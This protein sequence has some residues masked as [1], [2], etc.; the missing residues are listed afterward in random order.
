MSES[1]WAASQSTLPVRLGIQHFPQLV[2]PSAEALL[3]SLSNGTALNLF[4]T[5][6]R[7]QGNT[8]TSAIAFITIALSSSV[9]DLLLEVVSEALVA[10]YSKAD[11]VNYSE[12]LPSVHGCHED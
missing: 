2:T 10:P 12:F 1:G 8:A 9:L 6:T 5:I 4:L 7:A 11:I 3:F